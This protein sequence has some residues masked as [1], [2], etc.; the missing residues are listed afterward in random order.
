MNSASPAV[1]EP[2]PIEIDPRPC[3]LCGCTIDDMEE[4]IY[5]LAADLI[6]QWE[7]ADP[8]DCWRHTGEQEPRAVEM[9]RAPA[10]PYRTPQSTI[11]AFFYV[12]R[13]GD[14]DYLTQWLAQHSVDALHLH[15]LW[16]AKC[17]TAAA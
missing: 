11:D 8:R 10:Q 6:T 17:L 16:E 9:P 12:V 1:L 4:L 15:R 14:P 13:L 7:R 3:E 5:L 2:E